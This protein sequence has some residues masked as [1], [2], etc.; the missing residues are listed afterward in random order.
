MRDDVLTATFF[1]QTVE[2]TLLVLDCDHL[3][4]SGRHEVAETVLNLVR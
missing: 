2:Q 4:G 3:E 1:I